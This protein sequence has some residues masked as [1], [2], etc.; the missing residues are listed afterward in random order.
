[1]YFIDVNAQVQASE[2]DVENESKLLERLRT[3]IQGLRVSIFEKQ[4]R[5][6][7]VRNDAKELGAANDREKEKIQNLQDELASLN[8]AIVTATSHLES[9]QADRQELLSVSAAITLE[10]E[11]VRATLDA[12]KENAASLQLENQANA[13]VV[14]NLTNS[15]VDVR[16]LLAE[17]TSS[18]DDAVTARSSQAATL[19]ALHGDIQTTEGRLLQSQALLATLSACRQVDDDAAARL[20]SRLTDLTTTGDGL[21]T[22]VTAQKA[23]LDA[24]IQL[25][26]DLT[27][28]I[29]DVTA[30]NDAFDSSLASIKAKATSAHQD[31]EGLR[32]RL[33]DLHTSDPAPVHSIPAGLGDEEGSIWM[34]SRSKPRAQEAKRIRA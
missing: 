16:K 14:T 28:Q 6:N 26:T 31:V 21:Q 4:A 7:D 30:A 2:N 3:S 11:A 23:A 20:R 27:N 12:K 22:Q 33:T 15:L 18:I 29:R 9:I 10:L 34:S 32:C 24:L 13:K 5:G 25:K 19:A 8:V 1:M 17:V